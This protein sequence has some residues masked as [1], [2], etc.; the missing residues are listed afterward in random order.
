MEEAAQEFLSKLSRA[1][2]FV[3]LP[4]DKLLLFKRIMHITVLKINYQL[5]S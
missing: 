4:S 3:F 2:H 1:L 5:Q